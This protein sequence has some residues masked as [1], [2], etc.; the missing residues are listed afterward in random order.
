MI[1]NPY[2]IMFL[3]SN[4]F[5]FEWFDAYFIDV[6]KYLTDSLSGCYAVHA[7]LDS[8]FAREIP[9][10]VADINQRVAELRKKNR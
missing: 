8:K 6:E 4:T 10:L 3:N 5:N 2:R 7:P 9:K 1:G